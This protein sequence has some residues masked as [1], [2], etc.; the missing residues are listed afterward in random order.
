M[1]CT[2]PEKDIKVSEQIATCIF[3]V[4]QE[5]FT[6]ITRYALAKNVSISIKIIEKNILFIIEDD[7]IGFDSA[8]I[9]NKKS[10]GILGMKE[11][12]LSLGGKF[13]LVS[14]PGK[15][16]KIIVSLPYKIE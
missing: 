16:T 4:C 11:R 2:T 7:G 14:S 9:Q 1:K 8:S 6:N 13:E 10:F 15:G 12:V 5:A 3:R